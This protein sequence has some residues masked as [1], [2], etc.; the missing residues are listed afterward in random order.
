MALV[1]DDQ[2]VVREVVQQTEWP[3]PGQPPVEVARVVLDPGAITQ[4]FDHFEVVLDPL[5][6][7]LG[8]LLFAA[9]HKE[10]VLGG[11]VVLDLDHG[12]VDPVAGGDEDIGGIDGHAIELREPL[13]GHGVDGMDLFDGVAPLHDAIGFISVGHVH[14]HRIPR[15][16]ECASAEFDVVPGVEAVDELIEQFLPRQVFALLDLDGIGVEVGGVPDPVETGYGAD[17]DDV[18]PPGEQRA[19]GAEP[20]FL[21][22]VVD[23]EVFLDV[24][25]GGGEVGFGLVVVVVGDEVFDGVLGEKSAE[26]AIKLCGEGLV[27]AEHEGGFAELPDDVG[28]GKGLPGAGDAQQGVMPCPVLQRTNQSGDRFGLVAGGGEVGMQYKVHLIG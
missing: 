8:V 17:D 21:N 1:N 7:P 3:C 6:E 15:H 2:E 26:F 9:L 14:V 24:G 27:V 25:V 13:A 23:G 16:A 12:R 4:L 11:E 10:I 18:V 20:Q 19:G 22:L 5:L 28:H